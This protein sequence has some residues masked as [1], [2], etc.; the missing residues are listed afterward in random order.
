MW[1]VTRRGI[2]GPEA[3]R[4]R[5]RVR[6]PV[7]AGVDAQRLPAGC[8]VAGRRPPRERID[9]GRSVSGL[10]VQERVAPI[11]GIDQGFRLR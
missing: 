3:R 7:A 2:S 11:V 1:P 9:Q 6:R 8:V 10:V 4:C 5:Q